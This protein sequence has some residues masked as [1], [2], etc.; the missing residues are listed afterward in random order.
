MLSEEKP[1]EEIPQEAETALIDL[2]QA[3]L[4]ELERIP[5]VGFIKA[6]NIINFR[7]EHG[8]FSSVEDLSKVSGFDESLLILSRPGSMFRFARRDQLRFGR[9]RNSY[10]DY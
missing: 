4:I 7:L 1:G 10:P 3:S 5:G 2:N 9:R 8:A 6:Q